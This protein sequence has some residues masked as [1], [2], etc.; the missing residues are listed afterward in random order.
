VLLSITANLSSLVLAIVSATH[1]RSLVSAMTCPSNVHSYDKS[2]DSF[3]K[4]KTNFGFD[5]TLSP[6]A[7]EEL[8]VSTEISISFISL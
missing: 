3:P 8:S 2:E 1:S 4:V 6:N 5:V 7:Y